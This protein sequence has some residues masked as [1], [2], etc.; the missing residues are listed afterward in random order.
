MGSGYTV[1]CN[2][3]GYSFQA[4]LGC[5][6]LFPTVYQ[7]NVEKMKKGELGPEAKEF[8]EKYPKG[9]INS[10]RVI[11]KCKSCGNYDEVYDLT[12]Y[13]PKD[14]DNVPNEVDFIWS[15]DIKKSYVK[16]MEYPHKCSRCGKKSKVYKSFDR[17]AFNGELKCPHCDGMMGVELGSMLMWD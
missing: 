8:F 16:Y 9:V 17:K 4:S 6:R 15:N 7:E 14:D 1:K 12:M 5:G 13:I 11:A 2:K 3:C 10:E